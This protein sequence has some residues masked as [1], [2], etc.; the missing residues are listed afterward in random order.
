MKSVQST[1][2]DTSRFLQ[3][4]A[5]ISRQQQIICGQLD[6][7]LLLMQLPSE[8]VLQVLHGVLAPLNAD[9]D[10]LAQMIRSKTE[11]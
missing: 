4:L 3:T 7:L 1:E 10:A 11:D 2:N 9:M 8:S 5:S 6:E